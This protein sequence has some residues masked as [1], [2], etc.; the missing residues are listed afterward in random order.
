MLKIEITL[1]LSCDFVQIPKNNSSIS[2]R[3]SQN[4][5]CKQNLMSLSLN[6]KWF[7]F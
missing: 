2:S 1:F 4:V 6:L 3:S 5:I 7:N